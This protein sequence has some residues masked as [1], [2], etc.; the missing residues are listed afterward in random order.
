MNAGT[1]RKG[2]RSARGRENSEPRPAGSALHG[3]RDPSFPI[4]GAS[5]CR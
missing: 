3:G 4:Y 2:V 1:E 5:D